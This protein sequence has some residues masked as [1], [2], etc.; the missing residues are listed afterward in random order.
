MPSNV[1]V[2]VVPGA[3]HAP[4]V[5]SNFRFRWR[6]NKYCV[7]SDD[8][9]GGFVAYSRTITRTISAHRA[10]SRP[11]SLSKFRRGPRKGEAKVISA[12]QAEHD[13]IRHLLESRYAAAT[14]EVSEALRERVC[15][16]IDNADVIE[17]EVLAGLAAPLDSYLRVA[18]HGRARKLETASTRSTPSITCGAGLAFARAWYSWLKAWRQQYGSTVVLGRRGFVQL[19][20]SSFGK[21]L[22]MAKAVISGV[23][24]TDSR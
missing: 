9:S 8:V 22:R 1:A 6:P 23:S 3:R 16:S 7:C 4:R 13:S 15:R 21:Q 24:C 20:N 2:M 17:R 5:G 18:A 11:R 12:A 10:L 19:P 14:V